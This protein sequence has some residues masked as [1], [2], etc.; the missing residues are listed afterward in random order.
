MAANCHHH[1]RRPICRRSRLRDVKERQPWPKR[2]RTPGRQAQRGWRSRHCCQNDQCR[3]CPRR[4][5]RG[6]LCRPGSLA[7]QLGRLGSTAPKHPLPR[8]PRVVCRRHLTSSSGRSQRSAG[9]RREG[10]QRT[11]R[12]M[13]RPRFLS[14]LGLA[15]HR[16]MRR[17]QTVRHSRRRR[18]LFVETFRGRTVLRRSIPRQSLTVVIQ[19]ATWQA[20]YADPSLHPLTRLGRYSPGVIII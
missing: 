1:W 12:T 3:P 19:W 9:T 20:Y 5:T 14:R 8:S 6:R 17:Q 13:F 16:L 18:V 10:R 2:T 15:R 11:L 7:G 4:A